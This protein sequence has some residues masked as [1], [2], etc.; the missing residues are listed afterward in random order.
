M[1]DVSNDDL[2]EEY[3]TLGRPKTT[4][5]YLVDQHWATVP[6]NMKS[7]CA[8]FTGIEQLSPNPSLHHNLTC[9]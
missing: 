2:A 9:F 5:V 3:K 4:W 7:Q 1:D 8:L 6:L